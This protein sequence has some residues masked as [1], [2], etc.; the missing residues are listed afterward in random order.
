MHAPISVP[1][2]RP[3]LTFLCDPCNAR[4]CFHRLPQTENFLCTRVSNNSSQQIICTCSIVIDHPLFI[5]II[6]NCCLHPVKLTSNQLS[7]L[8]VFQ[9]LR[10]SSASSSLCWKWRYIEGVGQVKWGARQICP[11]SSW[12]I[13]TVVLANVHTGLRTIDLAGRIL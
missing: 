10:H 13:N 9:L 12:V 7:W 11:Q 8:Y 6:I 1:F 5:L 2:R 3:S 4:Q